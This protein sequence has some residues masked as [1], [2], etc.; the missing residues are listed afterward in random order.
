[1]KNHFITTALILVLLGNSSCKD[2]KM[3]KESSPSKQPSNFEAPKEE[4]EEETNASAE[5]ESFT[6]EIKDNPTDFVPAEYV[7]SEKKYG[8]LNKDTFDD[9]VLII[10]GTD[11]SKFVTDERRGELDRNRRGIIVLFKVDNGYQLASKNY[12]CFSSENEDG[13]VYYAPELS[14]EIIKGKLNVTYSHGRY[15]YWDFTFRFQNKDFELIGYD[16]SSNRGPTVLSETSINFSTKIK[17]VKV[18]TNQDDDDAEVV[19]KQSEKKIDFKNLLKLSEIKDFDE[20]N[21][22]DE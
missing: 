3:D 22:Y 13:G 10:K 5:K 6:R 11:K 21:F 9:C 16:S 17:I 2:N 1:M 18:N 20:L 7:L 4:F 8:D 15:G 19:F 12:D 14:V